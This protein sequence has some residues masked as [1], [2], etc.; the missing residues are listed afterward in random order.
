[1]RRWW[2]KNGSYSAIFLL[3]IYW[4]SILMLAYQRVI[5]I[6]IHLEI[7][8][9]FLVGDPSCSVV[10]TQFPGLGLF[11]ARDFEEVEPGQAGWVS[12]GGE[13]DKEKG[14]PIELVPDRLVVTV[15]SLGTLC[16]W[17]VHITL[18]TSLLSLISSLSLVFCLLSSF[19]YSVHFPT[20]FIFAL[21]S[22]F[23]SLVF[24]LAI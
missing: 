11:A 5:Y 20:F 16:P 10:K 12:K 1:M 14:E 3:V 17:F 23:T 4:F 13:A 2:N 6:Y 19:P 9:F 8:C 22:L 7:P 21:S 18:V 24:S 15:S